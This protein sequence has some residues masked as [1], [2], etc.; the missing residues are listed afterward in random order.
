MRVVRHAC[1]HF[2]SGGRGRH[3]ISN[4]H[5]DRH[6]ITFTS[7]ATSPPSYRPQ[8]QLLQSD[9][10]LIFFAPIT[11]RYSCHVGTNPPATWSLASFTAMENMTGSTAIH[12]IRDKAESTAAANN[13]KPIS[14]A[15]AAKS[16]ST[17]DAAEPV[18]TTR[19]KPVAAIDN[20]I[21]ASDATDVGPD[22]AAVNTERASTTV[23]S[24][25]ATSHHAECDASQS[26][27]QSDYDR[28]IVYRR[29]LFTLHLHT[30]E[31][32]RE[33]DELQARVG[34]PQLEGSGA[35][36][37]IGIGQG[38]QQMPGYERELYA[39]FGRFFDRAADVRARD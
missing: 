12:T 22:S 39:I 13:T 27:T 1:V 23:R 14:A 20:A 21:P 17:S 16:T 3:L 28:Y 4:F 35:C 5:T 33:I 31:L 9:R 11:I 19:G 38:S 32:R 8:P 24:R 2:T 34:Q 6:L 26:L 36:E 37:S 10:Y 15:D 25:A 30:I 7:T 18:G 29:K